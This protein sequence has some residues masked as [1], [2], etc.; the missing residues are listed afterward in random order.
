MYKV[1][2][3]LLLV[4]G[5]TL[6]AGQGG[7][8]AK[9]LPEVVLRDQKRILTSPGRIGR[10]ELKWLLPLAGAIGYLIATDERNMRERVRVNALARERSSMVS[11]ASAGALAAIPLYLYWR[12][13]RYGGDEARESGLLSGRAAI[14]SLIIAEAAGLV[15]RRAASPS[16][17]AAAAWAVAAV[18]ADRYPGW[19]T[20]VGVYGLASAVSLS[21]VTAREHSPSEVLAGSVLG[22]LVGRY[23]ARQQPGSRPAAFS[24]A[25]GEIAGERTGSP[26]IPMDS[27]VYP[28]LDRLAALGLIP[29]QIAGL[30]PWTRAECRRQMVEAQDGLERRGRPSPA[31]WAPRRSVC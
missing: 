22:W 19:L 11:N 15:T 30:R 3:I 28:A 20:K 24:P 16:G 2:W 17:H 13:W 12:G 31:R 21:R 5:T 7:W 14:G 1:R 9:S 4:A 6:E 25:G 26:Y 8:S 10:A 27:W 18:A 29:T 23:L